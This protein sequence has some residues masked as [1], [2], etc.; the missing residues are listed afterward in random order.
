VDTFLTLVIAL[1]G[2]AT[3]IGAVWTATLARRQRNEQRQFL[4]EQND[5]ARLNFT[6]DLLLRYVDRFESEHFLRRRRAAARYL[7]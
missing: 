3:G 1:G 4:R 6:V 7:T 2:I 5:R